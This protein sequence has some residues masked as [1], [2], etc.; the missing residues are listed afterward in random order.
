MTNKI[1]QIIPGGPWRWCEVCNPPDGEITFEISSVPAF[2]LIHHQVVPM[3][4]SV[5]FGHLVPEINDYL[6]KNT[7]GFLVDPLW[8]TEE[9]YAAIE[10]AVAEIHRD[11]ECDR[12]QAQG[13]ARAEMRRAVEQ[14]LTAQA[15]QAYREMGGPEFKGIVM[16]EFPGESGAIAFDATTE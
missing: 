15:R 13:I 9:I 8:R 14:Q 12:L 5:C 7:H 3:L 16:L 2:A 11:R 1:R 10:R 6:T 4:A